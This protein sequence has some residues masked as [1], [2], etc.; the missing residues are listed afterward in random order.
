MWGQR[1]FILKVC[2]ARR[3]VA[4]RGLIRL[5]SAVAQQRR[6]GDVGQVGTLEDSGPLSLFF[7]ASRT[8]PRYLSL[9]TR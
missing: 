9:I 8:E 1:F 5:A 4:E 3:D 7:I 2:T 6:P